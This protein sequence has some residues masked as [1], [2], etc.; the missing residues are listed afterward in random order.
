MVNRSLAGERNDIK[1]KHK[2][3]QKLEC[4]LTVLEW[5][6]GDRFGFNGNI[7]FDKLEVTSFPVR[8]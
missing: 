6:K 5:Y 2:K 3:C 7:L 1:C 4:F 8:S